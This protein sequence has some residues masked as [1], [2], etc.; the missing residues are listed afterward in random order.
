VSDNKTTKK[1]NAKAIMTDLKEGSS[2]SQLME[3][4]DLSFQGLQELFSKLVEAKLAT[5]A[6]FDKR[7]VKQIGTPTQQNEGTTCPYCGYTSDSKFER[8]PRCN[9]DT[10][11]WLDTV[12]LT[13]ILT[14]SFD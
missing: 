8:C 9:Q 4:Y 7:A 2:D 10:S 12:E 3:K 6:Y 1:I 5:K 13:K 11:E 14:G